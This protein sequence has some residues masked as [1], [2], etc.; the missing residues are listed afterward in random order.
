MDDSHIPTSDQSLKHTLRHT[1]KCNFPTKEGCNYSG[2]ELGSE[3]GK[4]DYRKISG[5]SRQNHHLLPTG[6]INRYQ[7]WKAYTDYVET[8]QAIYKLTKWCSSGDAN[9]IALSNNREKA[10]LAQ[11]PKH[12]RHH[13]CV[14]GYN[15]EV[16]MDLHLKAWIKAK[17]AKDDPKCQKKKAGEIKKLLATMADK[18]RKKLHERGMCDSLSMAKA[19][20]TKEELVNKLKG[21]EHWTKIESPADLWEKGVK[22]K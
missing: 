20:L 1:G 15:D 18:Y 16:I 11:L 6:C 7:A 19:V 22:K 12:N 13:W 3:A 14:G 5:F 2:R 9:M 17:E 10:T 21:K 4:P 8:I